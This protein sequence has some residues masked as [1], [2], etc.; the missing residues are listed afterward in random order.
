MRVIVQR[1]AGKPG[2]PVRGSLYAKNGDKE[3]RCLTLER[4]DTLIA[5]GTYPLKWTRSP[6]FSRARSIKLG[7]PVD[8]FTPEITD[9][10]GRAG[11]RI[12]VANYVRQLAGCIAPGFEFKDINAD[13][14]IDI[15]RSLAAYDMLVDFLLTGGI[16]DGKWTITIRDGLRLL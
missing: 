8:V 14:K 10:S 1:Q 6:R 15:A 2:E 3:F 16:T 7:K 11:L 4:P 12:H 13:G 9:V 5:A